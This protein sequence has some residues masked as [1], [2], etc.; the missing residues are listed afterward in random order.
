LSR[1]DERTS[2]RHASRVPVAAAGGVGRA[3]GAH[4]ERHAGAAVP[5][6]AAGAGAGRAAAAGATATAWEWNG[7]SARSS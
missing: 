4:R 7:R 3:G 6:R 1:L 5:L 2:E